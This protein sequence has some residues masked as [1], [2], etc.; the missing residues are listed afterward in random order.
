[1]IQPISVSS[2]YLGNLDGIL[3][4]ISKED[5]ISMAYIHTQKQGFLEN[6]KY[7]N[8]VAGNFRSRLLY[9]A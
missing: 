2:V 6:N 8:A 3:N 1:M 4:S 5:N 7:N 9:K